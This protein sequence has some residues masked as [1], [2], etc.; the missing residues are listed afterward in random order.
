M[1]MSFFKKGL[2]IFMACTILMTNFIPAMAADTK[3]DMGLTKAIG[4]AKEKIDVP[5]AYSKFT[6]DLTKNNDSQIFNLRWINP[7]NAN[8]FISISL[9]ED[10]DIINYENFDDDYRKYSNTTKLPKVSEKEAD[11][12]ART[13]MDQIEEGLSQKVTLVPVNNRY[14][15]S[16]EHYLNYKY[17][18]N[19]IS[20]QDSGL[21]CTINSTTGKVMR[22]N[23]SII[24]KLK[25]PEKVNVLN[26]DKAAQLYKEK[27]GLELVYQSGY[28]D[29]TKNTYPAYTFKQSKYSYIDAITGEPL[30]VLY[31]PM[32][33][34]GMYTTAD[35]A[36]S[37]TS[38]L[39]EQEVAA[40]NEISKI[41]SKEEAE[42]VLRAIS[43]LKLDGSYEAVSYDL[44]KDWD[45]KDEYIW[46]IRFVKKD[47][48]SDKKY[49]DNNIYTSIYASTGKLKSFYNY[50][51]T[52]VKDA[53][54]SA[55]EA[56]KI[57]EAFAKKIDAQ[58]FS[59]T[60][61][62]VVS[63]YNFEREDKL[64]TFSYSRVVNGAAYRSNNINIVVDTKT[65]DIRNYNINWSNAQ[66]KALD[67]IVS[68]DEAYKVLFNNIGLKLQYVIVPK[69]INEAKFAPYPDNRNGEV[70][71]VYAIDNKPVNIDA[72][73]GT[74][75]NYDG[76]PYVESKAQQYTDI[77]DFFGKEQI[78]ILA[79][80]HITLDGDKFL[81]NE[82]C[83]Q[84][85]FLTLLSKSINMYPEYLRVDS[86]KADEM[87]NALIRQGIVKEGEKAPESIIVKEQAIKFIIR[88]MNLEKAAEIKGIYTC[89]FIDMNEVNPD[90][91]GY[92]ALAK[93]LKI[94]NGYNGILSPKSNI[95]RGE[96]ALLIYN[97]MAN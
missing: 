86:K 85:D 62:N 70:K 21:G 38:N 95:T 87:Y 55:E 13:F 77:N 44:S 45:N 56:K 10:G 94:V 81:P 16:N 37:N 80:N 46:N 15:G 59:E 84:L 12:I 11:K 24:S 1:Y 5:E 68:I 2:G 88:A 61:E 93:G 47:N 82:N 51:P 52:E 18:I 90:L 17:V 79:E 76:Q 30:E 27:I 39:T 91:Y 67:K 14:Y 75:L 69:D 41:I 43:E 92:V 36:A 3:E 58:K 29:D 25:F 40:V 74:L 6:Y 23:R 33:E 50:S 54:Y 64:L 19:G 96:A 60:T 48:G 31:R 71:L 28:S 32:Y 63:N 66:F 89:D 35:K 22:F 73:T 78:Q 65:G 20:L 49:I 9:N 97:Y 34:D 8:Q 72:F 53:K 4:Q 7:K 42:K 83:T 26:A 57:A